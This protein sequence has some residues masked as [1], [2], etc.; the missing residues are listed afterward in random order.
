MDE[1]AEP[2]AYPWYFPGSKKKT[3]KLKVSGGKVW[4]GGLNPGHEYTVGGQTGP[5]LFDNQKRIDSLAT[6]I[7]DAIVGG[8]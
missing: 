8:M 4:A 2:N 6:K 5:V 1:G 7:A 3:G